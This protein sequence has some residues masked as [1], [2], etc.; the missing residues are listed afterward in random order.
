MASDKDQ[1][2]FLGRCPD[3]IEDSHV[4]QHFASL[5]DNAIANIRW[6]ETGGQFR[7]CGFV[8]FQNAEQATKALE[9]P[10]L[11]VDGKKCIVSAPSTSGAVPVKTAKR[12]A[13]T[14]L[15]QWKTKRQ[16][17][18]VTEANRRAALGGELQDAYFSPEWLLANPIQKAFPEAIKAQYTPEEIAAYREEN[19]I[20]LD[21]A[22]TDFPPLMKFSD[23][24]FGAK[25]SA[26]LANSF[27]NPMPIQS[28][29]WSILLS[30]YDCIGLAETGSGK[31]LA[32][33]L[34]GIV[35]WKA[36]SRPGS[37]EGP[38]ILVLA[39]TRELVLQIATELEKFRVATGLRVGMAY[40][41]SDAGGNRTVQGAK[42]IAGVDFLAATPGRLIDFLEAGILKLARATYVIL[43]EADRM[44]DMGFAPQ[45]QKNHWGDATRSSDADVQRYVGT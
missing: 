42:L 8:K 11:V 12:T 9:L 27:E 17:V 10:P 32:F 33:S 38:V 24:D 13:D 19:N 23:V 20:V 22:F 3:S 5:G 36:Q 26:L 18:G 15:E 28:Q 39:P 14:L 44:L 6:V 25:A 34:P 31:T 41:G 43:D 7:G 29:A 37:R 21:G 40:G 30:G 16:D 45:V 35:H 4:Y 2:V 1:T